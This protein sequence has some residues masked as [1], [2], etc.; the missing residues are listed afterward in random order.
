M[1]PMFL[2]MKATEKKK[3][4]LNKLD[5][6]IFPFLTVTNLRKNLFST[7]LRHVGQLDLGS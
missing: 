6:E 3:L 7:L 2:G 5:F 1:T 4:R